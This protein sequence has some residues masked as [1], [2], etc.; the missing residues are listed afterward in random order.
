M[1]KIHGW[2]VIRNRGCW[3]GSKNATPVIRSPRCPLTRYNQELKKWKVEFQVLE[4]LLELKNPPTITMAKDR[5]QKINHCVRLSVRSVE[6]NRRRSGFRA[7]VKRSEAS[8]DK[9]RR[10]RKTKLIRN[11]ERPKKNSGPKSFTTDFKIFGSDKDS[12]YI[13]FRI[14]RNSSLNVIPLTTLWYFAL[15]SIFLSVSTCLNIS[16]TPSLCHSLSLF[17][18][19]LNITQYYKALFL[20]TLSLYLALFHSIF[21]S[22]SSHS[23][24]LLSSI[25]LSNSLCLSLSLSFFS[26][27]IIFLNL[28]QSFIGTLSLLLSLSFSFSLSSHKF[29]FPAQ[30]I[31][32]GFK[33]K[34]FTTFKKPT[35][36]IFLLRRQGNET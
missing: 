3:L 34:N 30:S 26:L 14:I 20:L 5:R 21:Y 13:F 19:S 27:L 12:K 35:W 33:G 7:K 4:T 9:R 23:F 15:I 29:Y 32:I 22:L 18:R 10:S 8:F 31:G 28:T 24:S 11:F 25:S 1:K 2:A 6:A 16:L 17:Y 36:E